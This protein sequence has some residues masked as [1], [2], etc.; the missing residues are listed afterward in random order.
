MEFIFSV[1]N[2]GDF[3][4][5]KSTD[6]FKSLLIN[7]CLMCL[8]IHSMYLNWENVGVTKYFF[9]SEQ[10]QQCVSWGSSG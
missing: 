1:S 2:V 6:I 3:F 8:Y 10:S 7:S 4:F 9:C 5:V